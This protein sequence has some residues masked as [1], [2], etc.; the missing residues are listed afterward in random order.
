MIALFRLA[1]PVGIALFLL[2]LFNFVARQLERR[3]R[4]E[5]ADYEWLESWVDRLMR[6]S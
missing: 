2:D 3:Q 1:L 6:Q 4:R 5:V